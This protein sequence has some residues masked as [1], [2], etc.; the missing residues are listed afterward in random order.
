MLPP[1]SAE[2]LRNV[3]PRFTAVTF[4]YLFIDNPLS[5]GLLHP[6]H[7]PFLGLVRPFEGELLCFTPAEPEVE[8][9]VGAPSGAPVGT[10]LET[11]APPPASIPA[12][13]TPAP[14]TPAPVTRRELSPMDT[15][16]PLPFTGVEDLDTYVP[17]KLI[18]CLSFFL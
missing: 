16:D 15:D 14:V 4:F 8:L 10:P 3:S 11:P 18:P 2:E 17:G 1:L 7:Y 5:L 12:A 6:S 13:A 9:M